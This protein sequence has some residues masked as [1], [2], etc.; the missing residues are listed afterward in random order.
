[1]TDWISVK[2]R[3]EGCVSCKNRYWYFTDYRF[4][5]SYCP[6]CGRPLEPVGNA[7]TLATVSETER[8]DQKGP[9]PG[10]EVEG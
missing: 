5:P 8:V 6:S 7:D 9:E 3:Q 4:N 1:M 2:D 10:G